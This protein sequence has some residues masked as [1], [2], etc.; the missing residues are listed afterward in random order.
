[1]VAWLKIFLHKKRQKLQPGSRKVELDLDRRF[2][3]TCI[4]KFSH[5]VCCVSWKMQWAVIQ[6]FKV[7]TNLSRINIFACCYFSLNQNVGDCSLLFVSFHVIYGTIFKIFIKHERYNDLFGKCS[8]KDV[9][10]WYSQINNSVVR[11]F[12]VYLIHKSNSCIITILVGLFDFFLFV[13]VL[14]KMFGFYFIL[15]LFFSS[16]PL[17]V[18]FDVLKSKNH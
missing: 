15:L 6:S 9:K 8:V 5:G 2:S 4:I 7:Q 12:R 11:C 10:L 3:I 1:M 16:V 17:F 18:L 14:E 13:V